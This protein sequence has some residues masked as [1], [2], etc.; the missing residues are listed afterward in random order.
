MFTVCV[1]GAFVDG[2]RVVVFT[3][4]VVAVAGAGV[5][6]G[7]AVAVAGAGAAAGGG[8][9]EDGAAAAG[10]TGAGEGVF[11]EG[12]V[13]VFVCETRCVVV[14]AG[15]VSVVWVSGT[16]AI[17]PSVA[18]GTTVEVSNVVE[19]TAVEVTTVSVAVDSSTRVSAL[20]PAKSA[21]RRI[22]E[23]AMDE[24]IKAS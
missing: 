16:G 13:P 21:S 6:G 15:A 17:V 4:A 8:V 5:V 14:T 23:I 18:V 7:A 19:L 24:R 9:V 10:F 22:P 1:F 11:A 2:V 3:G 20:Q 12:G